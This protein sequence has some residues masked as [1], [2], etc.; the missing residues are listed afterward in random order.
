MHIYLRVAT[1]L[2][3]IVHFGIHNNISKIGQNLFTGKGEKMSLNKM[4]AKKPE[5]CSLCACLCF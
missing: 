5:I 2:L 3:V 4:A 1:F